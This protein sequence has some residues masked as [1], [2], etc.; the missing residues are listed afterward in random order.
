MESVLG[1]PDFTLRTKKKASSKKDV[2]DACISKIGGFAIWHDESTAPKLEHLT[3][4]NCGKFSSMVLVCQIYAPIEDLHRSLY[5]FACNRRECSLSS[6][7]WIVVR[8]QKGAE[9]KPPIMPLEN[10]TPLKPLLETATLPSSSIW[11]FSPDNTVEDSNDDLLQLLAQRDSKL[12]NKVTPQKSSNKSSKKGSSNSN[13]KKKNEDNKSS[14]SHDLSSSSTA[15]GADLATLKTNISLPEILIVE[16]ED[17]CAHPSNKAIEQVTDDDDD[18]GDDPREN[19]DNQAIDNH[20]IQQLL[21]NYLKDEDDAE[22]LRALEAYRLGQLDSERQE[23]ETIHDEKNFFLDRED[24]NPLLSMMKNTHQ[25]NESKKPLKAKT[26]KKTDGSRK[27]DESDSDN[28]IEKEDV[29]EEKL[30]K[31][32]REKVERYFQQ[33]IRLEPNQVLRYAYDS[34]PAWITYPFPTTHDIPL[35]PVC[36][37]RRVYECQLMPALL[38]FIASDDRDKKQTL[39]NPEIILE[40]NQDTVVHPNALSLE[41]KNRLGE[42]MDFGVVTIW[43]CPN[44]CSYPLTDESQCSREIAIVQPSPDISF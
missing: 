39:S 36:N 27:A 9:P 18:E 21:E 8:N 17:L 31:V 28:D 22:S 29:L 12:I 41:L 10:S 14:A 19:D 44:S 6:K 20:H 30:L 4:Q 33:R 23:K 37:S 34:E 13:S 40:P 5:L 2:I 42:G 38:S 11:S 24:D 16:V 25:K 35:C 3:C 15:K 26:E 32:R 7:G 43:S 1:V